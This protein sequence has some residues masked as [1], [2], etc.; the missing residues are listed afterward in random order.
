MAIVALKWQWVFGLEN[1]NLGGHRPL[2]L[3]VIFSFFQVIFQ[4]LEDLVLTVGEK[5][6]F[7][8]LSER[9]IAQWNGLLAAHGM[10]GRQ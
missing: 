8:H 2:F 3:V 5:I 10:D 9:I 7:H 6:K 4:Q 1:D